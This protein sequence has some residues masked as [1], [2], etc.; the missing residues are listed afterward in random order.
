MIDSGG[1]NEKIVKILLFVGVFISTM[2]NIS[3]DS[4]WIRRGSIILVLTFAMAIYSLEFYEWNKERSKITDRWF[5]DGFYTGTRFGLDQSIHMVEEMKETA[6]A[7]MYVEGECACEK[8][9]KALEET[10]EKI[11]KE[12]QIPNMQKMR[13]ENG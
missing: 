9:I 2:I 7:M 8:I 6:S 11:T 13:D 3:M 4:E 10:K 12:L 1:K 5:L